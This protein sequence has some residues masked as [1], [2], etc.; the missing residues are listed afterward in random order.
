[1]A[2]TAQINNTLNNGGR[3]INRSLYAQNEAGNY[4]PVTNANGKPSADLTAGQLSALAADETVGCTA[5]YDNTRTYT[6]A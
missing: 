1:M 5:G 4:A 6:R 2:N 3:V